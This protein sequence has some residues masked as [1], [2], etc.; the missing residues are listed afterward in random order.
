MRFALPCTLLVAAALCWQAR[1]ADFRLDVMTFNVRY[2]SA[3]D[4]GNAWERRKDILVDTLRAHDPDVFGVQEC[5]D[6]QA[7]YIAAHLDGHTWIGLGRNADGGGEMTAVFFR[8]GLLM[9][10]ESGHFWLSETPDVPASKS[11]DT[12]LPRIASWIKFHA[13]A[14]KTDFYF[15]NTHFDHRGVQARL[16]SAKLLAERIRPLAAQ[17]PVVLTGDFNALAGTSAPWQALTAH[18]MRDAW[19]RA[20]KKKGP[21]N[22][23]NGFETPGPGAAR[24]IDWILV[25]PRIEVLHCE[26]VTRQQDGRYPS[27]HFPVLAKLVLEGK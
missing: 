25:S 17:L 15:F 22:T 9:A 13:P 8:K 21:A 3:K 24:R 19:Q 27:D 16:E 7:A 2:G 14:S 18:G 10:L 23:W 5:L 1:A 11:W 26:T 6:F 12:S 4:G 20:A